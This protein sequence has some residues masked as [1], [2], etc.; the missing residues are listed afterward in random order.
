MRILHTS[1]WHLGRK[2]H[3]ADLSAASELWCRHVIDLVRERGIDAVLISGDVYDRG[4]PPTE[5]VE[6]FDAMLRELSELTTVILTSGNHDSAHRLGFGAGLMK[7]SVHIRTD[8]RNS[9]TPV[10]VCDKEGNLGALVYPIPYLDPDVERRRLAPQIIDDGGYPSADYLPRSHEAVLGAALDLIARD[11]ESGPHA[12]EDVARICM[13]HAF[14][15]GGEASISER[16]LHVGGVDSAP[17]GLFRLGATGS[18]PGPLSYVALGHLHSPQV[19]GQSHDPQMRYSGSPIA[20]S[21]SESRK[22]SS[23]LLDITGNRV[24]TTLIDAPVWRPVV[25]IE[26]TLE[27]ILSEAHIPDREKFARIIDTDQAR[28]TDLTSKI[29]RVFPFALDIQHRADALEK[30]DTFTPIAAQKPIEILQDFMRIAGNRELTG[31]ETELLTNTWEHT[32]RAFEGE[33]A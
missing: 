11:I 26:G 6:L 1:D 21:F 20:F 3:G 8:S 14:I 18:D 17:S 30:R 10:E 19:I 4:V 2:L 28:P 7:D 12:G 22:K 9:G 29:R 27:E 15:T 5:S 32:R 24:D 13:A 25:T 33:S 23:V 31:T 16:D